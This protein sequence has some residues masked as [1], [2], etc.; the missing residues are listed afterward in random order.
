MTRAL[1]RIVDGE[2]SALFYAYHD[3]Y[4]EGLGT[5]LLGYLGERFNYRDWSYKQ[6]LADIEDDNIQDYHM[7]E[8]VEDFRGISYLYIVNCP[9]KDVKCYNCY[10]DKGLLTKEE[11]ESP[12]QQERIPYPKYA[13]PGDP[14][15]YYKKE[16]FLE[17]IAKI[18]GCDQWPLEQ[19]V[20]FHPDDINE[21]NISYDKLKNYAID[22]AET[23]S[24][25]RELVEVERNEINT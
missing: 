6:I 7:A 2:E 21:A 15:R 1:I 10:G 4:P 23:C 12:K 16:T 24:K 3:G 14:Y 25:I 20:Q 22:L 9:K 18:V 13:R 19:Y 8:A 5:S 17:E 11:I